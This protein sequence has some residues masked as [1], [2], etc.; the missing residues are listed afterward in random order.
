M[1]ASEQSD[2]DSIA[3]VAGYKFVTLNDLPRWRQE[4][5]DFGSE[6]GLKGTILL[7]REGINLFVAGSPQ[8]AQ[9]FLDFLRSRPGLSDL[10]AKISHSQHIPFNRW[11]VKIKRE[12]IAF[13]DGQLQPNDHPTPKVSPAEF[14]RWI[15]EGRS[16]TILDVRNDYEVKLGAF[17]DALVMGIDNFREFPKRVRELPAEMKQTPIVMYCTGGIRCEKAGPFMQQEG[18]QEVYQ[19]EGGILKYFEECGGSHFDGECFVFDHRVAVDDHLDESD[20]A[21]CFAC[22]APLTVED[23]AS[24]EYIPSTSCPYCFESTQMAMQRTIAKRQAALQQ[25]SDPLPGSKPYENRRPM[26][27][28]GNRDGCKLIDFVSELHPHVA[29]EV[30]IEKINAG[31]LRRDNVALVSDAVLRAGER[32]EHVIPNTVEPEVDARIQVLY[33]DESIIVVNKPAPLPMHPCGRFNRNTLIALL[34][35]VYAPQKLRVAHRL[36][37]NTTGVVVIART[38]PVA[39][40]LH[41]QFVSAEVEK[42]YLARIHGHPAEDLFSCEESIGSETIAAGARDIDD[43]GRLARTDFRVLRRLDDG[44]TQV[45]V[46]PITGRTNQIRLHLAHLGHPILGDLTYNCD[47]GSTQTLDLD[48]PPLCLHAWQITFVHPDT[49]EPMTFAAPPPSWARDQAV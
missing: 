37:A 9:R 39:A 18:F 28:A 10:E 7:S 5:R 22:Q 8:A 4:L 44:T 41:P 11:L 47:S 43:S 23:Q 17:R 20:C 3:N 34:N 16:L 33:E 12:I 27:V 45:E 49:L 6:L 42:R 26:H 31:L 21:M 32:I 35:R 38:R 1:Q 40:R 13:D 29:R 19:L 48:D 2:T 25:I 14:K 46:L 15:D 36:D 24:P 30:W